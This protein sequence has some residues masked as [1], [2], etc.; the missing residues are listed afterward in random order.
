[1][2]K[3]KVKVEKGEIDKSLAA[4]IASGH[5]EASS[6][7]SDKAQAEFLASRGAAST[8]SGVQAMHVTMAWQHGLTCRKAKKNA[9]NYEPLYDV[10]WNS[11]KPEPRVLDRGVNEKGEKLKPEGYNDLVA[12]GHI[13]NAALT[14]PDWLK[15]WVDKACALKGISIGR[16]G[17]LVGK[18]AAL[19]AEPTGK[20]WDENVPEADSGSGGGA[21]IKSKVSALSRVTEGVRDVI[22]EKG[23]EDT[24]LLAAFFAAEDAIKALQ[25]AADR[26][27]APKEGD[28][29]ADDEAA[30]K[31]D[32]KFAALRAKVEA[33]RKGQPLDS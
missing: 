17:A 33:S 11:A 27:K 5:K 21:T 24:D 6:L 1:M 18:L 4:L 14:G 13:A 25:D 10:W 15:A 30:K 12:Y 22:D 7:T 26:Y 31:R 28:D 29:T 32:E 2:A 3:D 9:V 19:K 20:W 16:R 8:T 23:I